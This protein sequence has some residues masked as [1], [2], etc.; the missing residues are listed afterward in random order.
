MALVDLSFKNTQIAAYFKGS[1]SYIPS[2][3]LI[4]I[5]AH[6]LIRPNFLDEMEGLILRTSQ[7]IQE[8]NIR[9]SVIEK[10]AKFG[11]KFG[12]ELPTITHENAP[13]ILGHL[14]EIYKLCKGL[15]KDNNIMNT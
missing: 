12:A 5:H 15:L 10:F 14:R 13:K 1:D 7:L 4:Y 8:K 2:S 9:G 3:E 11:A 6:P